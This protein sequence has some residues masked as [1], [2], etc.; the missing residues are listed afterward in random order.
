MFS[1]SWKFHRCVQF[2]RYWLIVDF[3]QC[4]NN[5]RVTFPD[6]TN[7]CRAARVLNNCNKRNGKSFYFYKSLLSELYHESFPQP[8]RCVLI[9]ASVVRDSNHF[10]HRYND[11]G[12]KKGKAL[13]FGIHVYRFHEHWSS[14]FS[15]SWLF[16]YV[17][18]SPG[19]SAA[20]RARCGDSRTGLP[21]TWRTSD[22]RG[23]TS[24]G[25][26]SVSSPLLP[27]G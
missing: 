19:P 5:S 6:T 3:T 15:P 25:R 16:A 17:Q 24:P 8:G 14:S 1:F 26:P 7:V 4:C 27:S 9:R 20:T 11:Y 22:W 23:G 21:I 12:Y 18:S 10:P 13:A 2:D